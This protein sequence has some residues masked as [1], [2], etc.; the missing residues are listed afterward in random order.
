MWKEYIF[1]VNALIWEKV[2]NAYSL[3][4]LQ[5]MVEIVMQIWSQIW[6]KIGL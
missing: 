1:F 3:D 4:F 2:I 6:S 5:K